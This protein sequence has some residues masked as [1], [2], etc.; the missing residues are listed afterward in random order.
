MGP[1]RLID[2]AQVLYIQYSTTFQEKL[3]LTLLDSRIEVNTI[4]PIFAKELSF[5]IK[6]TDIRAQKINGT[7]LNT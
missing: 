1:K 4:Y 6:L 7:T 3:V 2:L 5:W